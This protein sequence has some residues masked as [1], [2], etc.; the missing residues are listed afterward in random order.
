MQKLF[1]QNF[2][3]GIAINE[4]LW[5]NVFTKSALHMVCLMAEVSYVILN[6]I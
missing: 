1:P 6:T 4:I 3:T 2:K 5:Y